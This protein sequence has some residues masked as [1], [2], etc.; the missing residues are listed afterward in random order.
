MPRRRCARAPAVAGRCAWQ[1][2]NPHAGLAGGAPLAGVTPDGDAWAQVAAIDP[3]VHNCAFRIE[4]RCRGRAETIL[5]E[6]FDFA[7]GVAAVGRTEGA[8]YMACTR[9]L[10]RLAEHLAACQY[11]LIESQPPSNQ[12]TVR[13][14][15][16]IISTL[17]LFLRGAGV[18]PLIVE[19][20]P[21]LKSAHFGAPRMGYRALKAWCLA[22]GLELLRRDGE[23]ATA[24]FIEGETKRDDHGDAVCYTKAWL[25]ILAAGGM[26]HAIPLPSAPAPA[27]APRAP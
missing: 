24:A 14:A 12:I 4:R 17:L 10:A 7:P 23:G 5:Q 2:F 25:D 3:G 8:A 21:A 16:H 9:T 13:L 6:S 11:V 22:K 19:V 1:I 20:D 27:E 18:R 26:T 15:Q